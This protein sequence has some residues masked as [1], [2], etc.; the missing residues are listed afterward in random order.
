VSLERVALNRYYFVGDEGV[1]DE[2]V[3][4]DGPVGYFSTLPLQQIKSSLESND[5]PA[6]YSFWADTYV[7]NEVFYRVM[8]AA[9]QDTPAGLVHLPISSKQVIERKAHY[10]VRSAVPSMDPAMLAKAVRIVVE[11]CANME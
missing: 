2:P 9:G 10:M 6:E 7:S 3:L 4:K 5:I 11:T 8:R 1:I